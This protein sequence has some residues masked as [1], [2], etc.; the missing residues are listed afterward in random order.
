MSVKGVPISPDDERLAPRVV[1]PPQ[2]F[3]AVNELLIDQRDNLHTSGKIRLFHSDIAQLTREKL[4]AED[5]F[6]V[7]RFNPMWLNFEKDYEAVGWRVKYRGAN[8]DEGIDAYF[9]FS[10][11]TRA[12]DC[13]ERKRSR[14]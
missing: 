12:H 3:D 9:V 10:R 14:N 7:T 4:E 8:I 11:V 13:D 1:P 6:V 5:G 2:V